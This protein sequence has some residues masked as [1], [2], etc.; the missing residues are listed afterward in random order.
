MFPVRAR[1]PETGDER[2]PRDRA[3]GLRL[4]GFEFVIEE[5]GSD[6]RLKYTPASVA[7][8]AREPARFVE[9]GD[10]ARHGFAAEADMGT[11]PRGGEP[12]RS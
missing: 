6:R 7:E 5:L 8:R 3:S 10:P 9:A 4:N 12:H 2:S 11:R 1:T